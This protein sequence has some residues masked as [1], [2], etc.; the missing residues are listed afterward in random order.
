MRSREFTRA[1]P[2]LDQHFRRRRQQITQRPRNFRD[3]LQKFGGKVT[4]VAFIQWFQVKPNMERLPTTP[5][6]LAQATERRDSA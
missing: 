5:G 6:G 3:F 4:A 1:T 2:Q